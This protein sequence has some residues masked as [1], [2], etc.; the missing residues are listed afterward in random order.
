MNVSIWDKINNK[1]IFL[2]S[3]KSVDRLDNYSFI[4]DGKFYHGYEFKLDSIKEC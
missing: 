1:W 3:V 4:I 2:T